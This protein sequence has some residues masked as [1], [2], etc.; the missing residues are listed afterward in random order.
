MHFDLIELVQTGLRLGLALVLRSAIGFERQRHLEKIVGRFSLTPNVT[1]AAW[2][3]KQA[4]PE[5]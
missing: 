4:I 2:Q 1:R 3:I 5:S